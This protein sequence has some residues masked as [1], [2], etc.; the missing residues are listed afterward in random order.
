MKNMVS[1]HVFPAK[2]D[3]YRAR[4]RAHKAC[5]QCK[6]RRKRCETSN[7]SDKCDPCLQAGLECSLEE[8]AQKAQEAAP[9]KDAP[10][11]MVMYQEPEEVVKNEFDGSG[12]PTSSILGG[13]GSFQAYNNF[14]VGQQTQSQPSQQSQGVSHSDDERGRPAQRFTLFHSNTNRSMSRASADRRPQSHLSPTVRRAVG[15]NTPSSPGAKEDDPVWVKKSTP[16]LNPHLYAYL[17]SINAFSMP[18][19]HIRDGL[20]D[21]YFEHMDTCLPLVDKTQFLNLHRQGQAPTLLMHAVLL[22]ASRHS[23]AQTYIQNL[24]QFAASTASKIRALLFAEVEQ[25]RLTLV[26]VY[27]L[28]SLHAEGPDGAEQGCSD[29]QHAIHYSISLGIHH[30]RPFINK[31]SLQ[32]LWWSIW[33]LDRLNS[34]INARPVIIDSRDV[35]VS[36]L[37]D[38]SQLARLV[39]ILE[40]HETIMNLYRGRNSDVSMKTITAM[41]I[42]RHKIQPLDSDSPFLQLVCHTLQLLLYPQ[43][44]TISTSTVYGAFGNMSTPIALALTFSKNGRTAP[45]QFSGR[46]EF[47]TVL[48]SASQIL[49]VSKNN[50]GSMPGLPVVAFSMQLAFIVLVRLFHDRPMPFP[51]VCS[52]LDMYSDRWWA[53]EAMSMIGGGLLKGDAQQQQ[54]KT[55]VPAQPPVNETPVRM[56]SP[57][58]MGMGSSPQSMNMT[59]SPVPPAVAVNAPSSS[60]NFQLLQQQALDTMMNV[61]QHGQQQQQQQQQQRQV[62]MAPQSQN[63]RTSPGSLSNKRKATL[64]IPQAQID[65][66]SQHPLARSPMGSAYSED[67]GQDSYFSTM[68]TDFSYGELLGGENVVPPAAPQGDQTPTLSTVMKEEYFSAHRPSLED[69]ANSGGTDGGGNFYAQNFEHINYLDEPSVKLEYDEF[70]F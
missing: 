66:Y 7:E 64:T 5:D 2:N 3:S 61:S 16:Q 1:T 13:L 48:R 49:H 51:D 59:P 45:L 62:H 68:N 31:T 36:K 4:K 25:D 30:D 18:L 15:A 54:N 29:L 19:K 41:D 27:A 50:S 38:N 22:A 32:Q 39:S 24:R 56:A 23:Q 35:E 14:G 8:A 34:L 40:S 47:Q 20:V 44:I 46:S 67:L 65:R 26:R 55:P 33:C 58:S 43:T 70:Q 12:G 52:I 53:T 60:Q 11:N 57:Q 42:V 17:S 37:E 10:I 28:I 63:Q 6:R 69:A 21:I 9:G